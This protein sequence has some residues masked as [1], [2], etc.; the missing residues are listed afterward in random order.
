MKKKNK[1]MYSDQKFI[2]KFFKFFKQRY[3]DYKEFMANPDLFRE[4]GM[5]MYCGRQGDGKTTAMIEHLERLRRKYPNAIIV[6]N[7][8]YKYEHMSFDSWQQL[9]E[10]RNGEKGVIFAIDEIQ[11]EFN[12]N[13]SK[14]FP[15]DLLAEITQQRKQRIKLLSTSQVFLRVAKPLRENTYEVVECKTL[16]GCW[17]FTKCF[18]ADDYNDLIDNK[19]NAPEAKM[20]LKR[21]Y[22]KNFVHD[23]ELRE[24]FD[25]YAKVKR[26]RKLEYVRTTRIG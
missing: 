9:L 4:Y 6:T 11:N 15:E 18:D 22:R 24:L 25:S 21:K 13:H 26:M 1:K 14:A 16:G 2:V 7:F 10:I 19:G 8:G 3:L 23:K 20:K 5:T 12:T 17:T